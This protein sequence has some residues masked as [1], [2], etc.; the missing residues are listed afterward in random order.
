MGFSFSNLLLAPSV[1]QAL[2]GGLA[3]NF[4]STEYTGMLSSNQH[5]VACDSRF[6]LSTPGCSWIRIAFMGALSLY[7]FRSYG[8]LCAPLIADLLIPRTPFSASLR[9]SSSDDQASW[10]NTTLIAASLFGQSVSGGTRSSPKSRIFLFRR[11]A[12][13]ITASLASRAPRLNR[14]MSCFAPR[15]PQVPGLAFPATKRSLQS[16][17]HDRLGS[18]WFVA[19]GVLTAGMVM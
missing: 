18:L 5:L 6:N 10:A 12:E 3:W 1:A 17:N 14:N 9:V 2:Q 19:A 13:T 4:Q 8:A 11:D 15:S 16:G 7:R